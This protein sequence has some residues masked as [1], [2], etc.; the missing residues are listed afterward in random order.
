MTKAIMNLIQTEISNNIYEV[1]LNFDDITIDRNEIK[2]TFGYKNGDIHS[3]FS[4]MIDEIL[5]RFPSLS[6]I[7]TGYRIVDVKKSPERNDGLLLDEKFFKMD[8]IVTSQLKKSESAAVFVCTIGNA[9]EN[10]S[11]EEMLKGDPTMAYFIDTV[12]SVATESVVNLLHDFIGGKMIE[13]NLNITNR[14]SPGYC[15]WHVEEQHLLF[16]LLPEKFCGVNLT[17]SALMIPIKS[18]SGIIGIGK[19]VKYAEYL[20]D[21]CGVKDCT[22]RFKQKKIERG[23]L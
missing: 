6:E 12:A 17:D 23:F 3:H 5:N 19:K 8:K 16:S 21:R 11:K 1:I 13:E 20:C 9:M 4:E 7:K 22:Y 18:V 10:W 15:N 14:Y 2:F